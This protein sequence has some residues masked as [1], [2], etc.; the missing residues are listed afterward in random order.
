M[1]LAFSVR[2]LADMIFLAFLLPIKNCLRAMRLGMFWVNIC[3]C[4]NPPHMKTQ[5]FLALT[6]WGHGRRPLIILVVREAAG[7]LPC[8]PEPWLT[9]T[10]EPQQ[11]RRR[12]V[13][14]CLSPS[15][16]R[17]NF[18]AWLL[19]NPLPAGCFPFLWELSESHLHSASGPCKPRGWGPASASSEGLPPSF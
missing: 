11:G 2:L 9:S 7:F 16:Q 6:C 18:L 13:A 5:V 3:G 4:Q 19:R 15:K 12:E 14:S 17:W 8:S 1:T 10:S